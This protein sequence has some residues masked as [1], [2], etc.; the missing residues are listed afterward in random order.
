[1]ARFRERGIALAY[2]CAQ[3]G[4]VAQ[5]CADA[6]EPLLGEDRVIPSGTNAAAVDLSRAVEL[7]VTIVAAVVIGATQSASRAFM[8][9]LAPPDRAGEFMGFLALSGKASAIVGPLVY[10]GVSQALADPANPGRSHRIAIS[11]IGLFFVV[12]LLVLSRVPSERPAGGS[13]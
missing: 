7:A 5:D 12:A 13:E 10:G 1:M 9:T 2:D 6:A 11:V 8:A 4:W 3:S